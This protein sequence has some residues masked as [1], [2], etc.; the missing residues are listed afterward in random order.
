MMSSD[1]GGQQGQGRDSE[2]LAGRVRELASRG[3]FKEAEAV[4]EEMMNMD[5]MALT[6][7]VSTAEFIEEQKTKFLDAD[8]LEIWN[9]LYEDFSPEE[10]NGVFYSLQKATVARGKM[11]ITQGKPNNLLYF[12]ES[13]EVSVFYHQNGKK[14]EAKRAAQEQGN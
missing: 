1:T 7:I 11:L 4:R 10:I 3:A 6:L 12:I 8:H 5:S 2:V 14:E 9:E 13:G